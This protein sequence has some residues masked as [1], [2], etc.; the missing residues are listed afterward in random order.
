[1]EANP[2]APEVFSCVK[3][4]YAPKKGKHLV[5]NRK[6]K[7]LILSHS[8]EM[9][10]AER[11]MIDLF[12]YWGAKGQVEPY[13]IIRR[14]IKNMAEQLR[15]RNW[16]YTALYYT[17]W[18]DRTPFYERT[19]EAIYRSSLFNSKAVFDVEKIIEEFKP[20]LVMTN[21]IVS[22]WAAVAAYFQ[23]VP[24]IW[25]VREYGDVDHRHIFELGREKMLEDIDTMSKLVVTNSQTLGKYISSNI[26]THKITSLYTPFNI[27]YLRKKSQEK[28]NN[29]F[30]SDSSLKLVITGRIAQSKGQADAAQ[31]VGMLIKRGYDAE[32][33]VIGLPSD[34]EDADSL[35]EVINKYGIESKVHLVGHQS[36][37]LAIIKYADIGIMASRQEAFG[38]V[39]FEYMTAGLAVVGADSGATPEMIENN[40]NGYLYE[41]GNVDSL[42][43]SLI[44]Y[45]EDRELIGKHG[46]AG[47]KKT[48]T[49][50]E[51]DHN[52]DTL[53]EKLC[54]IIDNKD[55]YPRPLNFAH[56]WLEYP[57]VAKRYIKDSQVISIKR[58][59]YHRFRHLGKLTYLWV[60]SPFSKRK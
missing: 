26:N 40:K 11:S 20:D 8:S 18:S 30:K 22:P 50:M 45:A 54:V 41:H 9:A 37:P 4:A 13:F 19:P 35:H 28:A 24:H 39:T 51:G 58:L 1:M 43:A 32:L 36:N 3:K 52:A 56:R 6:I 33:C 34:P 25:F 47:Q 14:P 21:T 12:D 59:A 57:H 60:T 15:K 16:P 53:F 31:A 46:K 38:R 55:E 10:G 7:V 49:M 23:G 44:N 5:S 2:Q 48:E 29:P 17:N 27:G 42:V